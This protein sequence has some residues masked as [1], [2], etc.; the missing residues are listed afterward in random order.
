M[1]GQVAPGWVTLCSG[2]RWDAGVWQSSDGE[3]NGTHRVSLRSS[4]QLLTLHCSCLARRTPTS[5]RPL[6]AS[7]PPRT[8]DNSTPTPK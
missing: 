5:R 7:K 2:I 8:V 6:I 4:G 1:E 3:S